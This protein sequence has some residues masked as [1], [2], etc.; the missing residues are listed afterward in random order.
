MR[1][2]IGDGAAVCRGWFCTADGDPTD[3]Q[4]H[5]R[6][7]LPV[8]DITLITA[9]PFFS[10]L[11]TSNAFAGTGRVLRGKGTNAVPG[12]QPRRDCHGPPRP[13]GR[14]WRGRCWLGGR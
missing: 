4:L 13:S 10:H 8:Q 6:D 11:D 12:A 14:H 5:T 3:R 9:T 7:T 2:R 1:K